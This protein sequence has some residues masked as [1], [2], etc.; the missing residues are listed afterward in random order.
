MSTPKH[1]GFVLGAAPWGNEGTPLTCI[2]DL[3]TCQTMIDLFASAGG[4]RI[5][6]SNLYG[7]GTTDAYIGKIDLKGVVADTKIWPFAPGDHA[8]EKLR[9]AVET[10][11]EALHPHKIGVLYL[12]LP[13]KSVP[14]IDTARE[15]DALHKRGLFEEFGLSNYTP[16]EIESFWNI[17]AE[18]NWIKPT[19]YQGKYNLLERQ[20][21]A[22][23][24]PVLRKL[25]IRFYAFSPLAG[26][27]L[28][29][30]LTSQ[31]D[32]EARKALPGRF[33]PASSN[34]EFAERMQKIY[35]PLLPAV[36]RL[37]EALSS[38]GLSVPDVAY[39]WLHFHSAMQNDDKLVLG[40][41]SVVM[42]EE[43][44]ELHATVTP[45]DEEV[46]QLVEEAWK[47]VAKN[48]PVQY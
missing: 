46:V 8:S 24:F 29:G 9:K 41:R 44:I 3:G 13:D 19:V 7:A 5:D 36:F 22:D 12:H 26:G 6:S 1:L 34:T 16:Q 2:H 20:A 10:C 14:F 28:S 4:K 25:G 30:K 31:D 39:R 17:C 42:L 27:V 37:F 43:T 15:I 38:R 40:A 35:A 23:L 45:L 32:W 21:E 33:N 11:V 48:P 18:N 47:M